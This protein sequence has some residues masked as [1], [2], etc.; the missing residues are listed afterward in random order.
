MEGGAILEVAMDA[1][2][3]ATS[4]R[5]TL[6]KDFYLSLMEGQGGVGLSVG[7]IVGLTAGTDNRIALKCIVRLVA[8][9]DVGT[10]TR[11]TVGVIVGLTVGAEDGI[12]L[13]FIVGVA[14]GLDVGSDG[15]MDWL[16]NGLAD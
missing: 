14:L 9:L 2:L 11:L 1:V 3:G 15:L 13:R 5:V 10:G 4:L 16:R 8:G 7:V 6:L 12:S